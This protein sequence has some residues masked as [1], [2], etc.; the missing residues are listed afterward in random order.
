MELHFREIH[1]DDGT[2]SLSLGDSN[3]KPLKA[4]LKNQAKEF[5]L[6]NIAKTYVLATDI[7]CGTI[8]AYLSLMCSDIILLKEQRPP[9]D[10]C[11]RYDTYPAI[12]IARLAVDKS[13][14]GKG[15]GKSLIQSAISITKDHIAPRVGCRYIIVDSKPNAINFYEKIGFKLLKHQENTVTENP[16]LLLDIHST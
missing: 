9:I 15:I 6:N 12:K 1:S 11:E 5:H 2:N 3:L 16:L 7:A 4:F 10:S 14:Q 13:L 8:K